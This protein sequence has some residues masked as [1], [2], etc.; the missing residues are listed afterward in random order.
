MINIKNKKGG[1]I[2]IIVAGLF[3]FL[4][5]GYLGALISE[6]AKTLLQ[7]F[8]VLFGLYFGRMVPW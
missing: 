2:G 5:G 4:L 3:G 6:N 8:G 1:A 7:I